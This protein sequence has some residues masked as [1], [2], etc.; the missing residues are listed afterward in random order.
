MKKVTTNSS[1]GDTKK[2]R[3]AQ[4]PDARENQLIALAVDLVEKK[5]LDG[6]AT[7]QEIIHYLKLGSSKERLERE[8]LEE[9]NKLLRAKTDRLQADQRSD[10]FYKEVLEAFNVYRGGTPTEEEF[11]DD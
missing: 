4:N 2:I 8:K 7:S 9:E 1:K 6:T 10:T 11:Y 5:L 3:P